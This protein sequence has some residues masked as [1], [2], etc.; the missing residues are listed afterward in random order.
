MKKIQTIFVHVTSRWAML[1]IFVFLGFA[2]CSDDEPSSKPEP[3]PEPEPEIEIPTV[4][5]TLCDFEVDE[6]AL[7]TAGWVKAFD[8]NFDGDL[9]KWN[10]WV[11]GAFNNELQHYQAANAEIVDGKL[12]ITAKRETVKGANNPYDPTEKTFEFT[13]A[14]LECKTNVSASATTPKVRMM[15]RVKLPAGYALWPA[16][17]SYGD[18]WPTQGEIDMVEF[19]G[20]DTKKYQTNYFYGTAAGS[21]LV[22]DGEKVI[23]AD[24]DLTECYHI[25]EMIWESNKLT[26]ILDGT[27]V[28]VKTSGNYISQMYGKQQR[29]TLNLA[30]GGAF[31][32]DIDPSQVEGGEMEV[33]WVRVFTSN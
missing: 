9:S 4:A 27:I 15:A 29:I 30:V 10:T 14:R 32:G 5:P 6:A 25:F 20:S 17:W 24:K 11:G 2:N 1:L 16:F 7:T 12:V 22:T 8:E 33:D 19:R 28:E 21:N 13:S 3:E 31:F 23:T 18:P 26:S